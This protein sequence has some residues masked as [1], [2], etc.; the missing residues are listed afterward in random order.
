M[1]ARVS[2]FST[3]DRKSVAVPESVQDL[4]KSHSS[5]YLNSLFNPSSHFYPSRGSSYYS[6]YDSCFGNFYYYFFH[7]KI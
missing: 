5:G 6:Y 7:L 4:R 3:R 2:N 1:Q